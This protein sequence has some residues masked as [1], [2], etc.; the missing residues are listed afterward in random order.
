MKQVQHTITIACRQRGFTDFTA[1]IKKQVHA[2]GVLTGLVTLFLKDIGC[3]LSI[4]G[5]ANPET[6]QDMEVLITHAASDD[7]VSPLA[8]A[9]ETG[10]AHEHTRMA[11]TNV[12]LSIPV[13]NGRLV[14]GTW[15]AVCLYEHHSHVRNRHV[16]FHLVGN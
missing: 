13:Q 4:Q 1:E 12:F 5:N 2:S 11:L 6:L 9:S 14:L 7:H 16:F 8:H 3:S 10:D 15:Q